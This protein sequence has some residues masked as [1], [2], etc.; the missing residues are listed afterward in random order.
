MASVCES[1]PSPEAWS[2]KENSNLKYF[3]TVNSLLTKGY[4]N[5]SRGTPFPPE[6]PL[7]DIDDEEAIL[8]PLYS[9][10]S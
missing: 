10:S 4:W 1:I 7:L 9:L 8:R 2:F 5:A 6:F 3:P